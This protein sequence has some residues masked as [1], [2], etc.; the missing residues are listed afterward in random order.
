MQRIWILELILFFIEGVAVKIN[1]NS[2]NEVHLNSAGYKA[3][4]ENW[5]PHVVRLVDSVNL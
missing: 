1:L 2:N 4:V 5:Y 3:V